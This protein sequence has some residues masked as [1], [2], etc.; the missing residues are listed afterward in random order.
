MNPSN[1]K[2]CLLCLLFLFGLFGHPF[3]RAATQF[4]VR[5]IGVLPSDTESIARAINDSGQV[6]GTS[7]NASGSNAFRWSANNGIEAL[8]LPSGSGSRAEAAGINAAG[9]IVGSADFRGLLWDSTTVTDLS[10]LP[11]G[12]NF[13][14]FGISNSGVIVGPGDPFE[15]AAYI[16]SGAVTSLPKLDGNDSFSRALAINGRGE[17]VGQSG[18]SAVIWISH[19]PVELA[20]SASARAINETNGIAGN[21]S[22]SIPTVPGRSF[23]AVLWVSGVMSILSNPIGFDGSVAVG[24]NDANTVVGFGGPLG[25]LPGLNQGAHRALLW[26]DGVAYDLN[27][28]TTNGSDWTLLEAWDV[29]NRG[30]IVGVGLHHDQGLRAFILTPVPEPASVWTMLLGMAVL[31]GALRRQSSIVREGHTERL[32]RDRAS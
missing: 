8:P 4:T 13:V 29:N 24:I 23:Q 19:S 27:S 15:T 22:S 11:G 10:A 14:P 21:L 18:S 25:F 3:A 12:Q 5:D 9:Q 16:S 17:I 30:E 6:I 1:F 31:L 32:L 26:H 7:S 28:L 2:G 20:S